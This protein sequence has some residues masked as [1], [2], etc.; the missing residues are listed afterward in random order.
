MHKQEIAGILF[1]PYN[2]RNSCRHR[3]CGNTCRTDKRIDFP[4]GEEV[5][6]LCKQN[7]ADSAEYECAD[8]HCKNAESFK[9]QES[10]GRCCRSDTCAEKNRDNVAKFVLCGLG[11]SFRDA[12][13][14]QAYRR[15]KLRTEQGAQPR[16]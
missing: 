5:H 2:L 8:A 15:G 10:S 6:E 3:D 1:L 14:A 9:R 16:W 12:A 13:F 4:A 11:K 7:A